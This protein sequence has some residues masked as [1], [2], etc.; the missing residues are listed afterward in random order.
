MCADRMTGTVAFGTPFTGELAKLGRECFGADFDALP[1][2]QGKENRIDPVAPGEAARSL[3]A[4]LL[5]FAKD[6]E[7]VQAVF[8]LP[9][10]L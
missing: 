6:E 10:S 2:G 4:N 9:S 5:F 8:I 3:L 1:A 7:L